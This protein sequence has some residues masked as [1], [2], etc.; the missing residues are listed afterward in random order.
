MS[1]SQQEEIIVRDARLSDLDHLVEFNLAMALETEKRNLSPPLLRAGVQSVLK[2][3]SRGFYLVGEIQ[4]DHSPLIAGQLLIT[5]EWSDWRNA[6]FWWIQSVYVHQNWRHRGVFRAL[7]QHV[8]DQAQTRSDVCGVRLY[9]EQENAQ[10]K[11]VY[12][13]MGL[14]VTPYQM[15]ERDFVMPHKLTDS[16]HIP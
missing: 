16:K 6:N 2:Q 1:H 10:A 8:Y 14:V 7:Y 5:Y 13:K 3:P 11:V 4:Q 15:L 9:V 12:A